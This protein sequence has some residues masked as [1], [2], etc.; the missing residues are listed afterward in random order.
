MS[1]SY[2][3]TAMPAANLLQPSEILYNFV[4][5]YQRMS[6]PHAV[7]GSAVARVSITRV[8]R[9]VLVPALKM[10]KGSPAG[11][12][13]AWPVSRAF[14]DRFRLDRGTTIRNRPSPGG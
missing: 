8:L 2:S 6:S 14:V 5:P 11:G 9:W 3:A 12:R 10:T 4:P 7:H 1:I 13:Y